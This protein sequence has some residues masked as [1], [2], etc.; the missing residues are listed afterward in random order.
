MNDLFAREMGLQKLSTTLLHLLSLPL[1]PLWLPQRLPL[2]HLLPILLPNLRSNFPSSHW[3]SKRV[4][5]VTLLWRVPPMSVRQVPP[6]LMTD[7]SD[8][9]GVTAQNTLDDIVWSSQK[10]F[11]LNKLASMRK[12]VS[13]TT[14][15]NYH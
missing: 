14:G 8:V 10:P 2:L 13:F 1:L 7:L 12:D 9:C 3:P 6:A 11:G 15:K 4:L 5:L